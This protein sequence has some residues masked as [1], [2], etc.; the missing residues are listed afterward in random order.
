MK[1]LNYLFLFSVLL[2]PACGDD[3]EAMEEP[4]EF[5]PVG[6]CHLLFDQVGV[7]VGQQGDCT[8]EDHWEQSSLIDQEA[9]WLSFED[10]ITYTDDFT[11]LLNIDIAAFPIPAQTNGQITLNISATGQPDDKSRMRVAIINQDQELLTTFAQTVIAGTTA[12]NISLDGLPASR[13]YR[14]Y[15]QFY[16]TELSIYYQ[17]YGDFF[18]CD[19]VID[20]EGCL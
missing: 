12:I 9:S 6:E 7:P 3:D 8:E 4:R 19:D 10:T 1:I 5:R 13:S 11:R 18:I 2:L 20:I 14:I 17:G 16:E 15:Y